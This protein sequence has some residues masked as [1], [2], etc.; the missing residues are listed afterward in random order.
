MNRKIL[1]YV[2]QC[3]RGQPAD[4]ARKCGER[5][6]TVL[7]AVLGMDGFAGAEVDDLA[8]HLDLLPLQAGEMHFDAMALAVVERA[9][10]ENIQPESTAKLAVDAREQIEIEFGGHACGVV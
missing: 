10:L 5:L 8:G 4:A 2:G 1:T 9:M 6:D 7:V 3:S